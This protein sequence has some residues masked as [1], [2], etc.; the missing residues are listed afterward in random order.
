LVRVLGILEGCAILIFFPLLR[1]V[2]LHSGNS[3]FGSGIGLLSGL[4]KFVADMPLGGLLA[5]LFVFI[6]AQALMRMI[7]ARLN[8]RLVADFTHYLRQRLHHALVAADWSVF[9]R[10]RGSDVIR[11]L[12]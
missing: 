4:R 6:A 12:T 7:L 10:L 11:I 9:L 5:L 8:V 3:I 2:G 1:V